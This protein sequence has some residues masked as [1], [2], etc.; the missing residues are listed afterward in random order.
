MKMQNKKL[1]ISA[2]AGLAFIVVAVIIG[3]VSTNN[4]GGHKKGTVMTS[5]GEVSI[6]GLMDITNKEE[7]V[8]DKTELNSENKKL[9]DE[10]CKPYETGEAKESEIAE[11]ES[12]YGSIAEYRKSV[13]EQLKKQQLTGEAYKDV[14]VTDADREE[15]INKYAATFKHNNAIMLTFTTEESCRDFYNKFSTQSN[16]VIFEYINSLCD[17]KLK[18]WSDMNDYTEKTG[19]ELVHSG[20]SNKYFYTE[21]KGK[22]EEL[23]NTLQVG[24]MSEPTP[25]GEKWMLIR[26]VSEGTIEKDDSMIDMLMLEIKQK[27]AYNALI[28]NSK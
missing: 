2:V 8:I 23:Y 26:K 14:K 16:D 25:H 15:F 4:T 18:N 24:Q 21:D 27:E 20:Y 3:V 22:V 12:K 1:V 5:A 13:E 11:I 9:L 10:I 28:A 7:K 19:I 17:N 6:E